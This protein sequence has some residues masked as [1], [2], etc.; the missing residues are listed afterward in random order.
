M[1]CGLRVAGCGNG[2]RVAGQ[3]R[4]GGTGPSGVALA[5][6]ASWGGPPHGVLAGEIVERHWSWATV[7]SDGQ[8]GY[9]A[10]GAV[11]RALYLWAPLRFAG[12]TGCALSPTISRA[13]RVAPIAHVSL[14]VCVQSLRLNRACSELVLR[15]GD[16][17]VGPRYWGLGHA[18]RPIAGPSGMLGFARCLSLHSSSCSRRVNRA[19]R[20]WGT[21][22]SEST[23]QR[24]AAGAQAGRNLAA[25]NGAGRKTPKTGRA[26]RSQRTLSALAPPSHGHGHGQKKEHRQ[27]RRHGRDPSFDRPGPRAAPPYLQ[28]APSSRDGPRPSQSV[29]LS[30][31]RLQQRPSTA[32]TPT[33]LPCTAAHRPSIA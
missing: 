4:I 12:R 6:E 14:R 28:L 26:R 25:A 16:A 1:D 9:R 17:P 2:L 10:D 30:S 18:A 21:D 3:G 5:G 31:A 27:R 13:G 19:W 23:P 33:E 22:T 29:V 8:P 20:V 15:Q 7:A 11:A 32:M 24:C